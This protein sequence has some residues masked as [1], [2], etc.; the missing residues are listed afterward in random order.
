[1]ADLISELTEQK[2]K[3]TLAKGY[4]QV[5]IGV[6]EKLPDWDKKVLEHEGRKFNHKLS[7]EV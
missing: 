1:M 7:R 2:L 3:E 5:A 4:Q 6:N